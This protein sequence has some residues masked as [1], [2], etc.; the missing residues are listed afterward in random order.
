[1]CEALFP[2]LRFQVGYTVSIRCY[3]LC[4]PFHM[5]FAIAKLLQQDVPNSSVALVLSIVSL[6]LV[7]GKQTKLTILVYAKI[8]LTY[9]ANGGCP[10]SSCSCSYH[11]LR[12]P[13]WMRYLLQTFF[14]IGISFLKNFRKNFVSTNDSINE[15]QDSR[16]LKEVGNLARFMR[17][18]AGY[19]WYSSKI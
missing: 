18:R 14:W 11:W 12:P 8:F 1:M 15:Q 2:Y 9:K 17:L 19:A 7:N 10:Q 13:E 5:V 16:L 3:A 6:I 4:T